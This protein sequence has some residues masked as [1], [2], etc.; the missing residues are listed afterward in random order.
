[1]RAGLA[2]CGPARATREV[3]EARADS[4]HAGRFTARPGARPLAGTSA[5]VRSGSRAKDPCS[6]RGRSARR[7]DIAGARWQTSAR[8]PRVRAMSARS[9]RPLGDLRALTSR[10]PD[11]FALPGARTTSAC[12]RRRPPDDGRVVVLMR[13]DAFAPLADPAGGIGRPCRIRRAPSRQPRRC[14]SRSSIDGLRWPV[15]A[16]VH[17]ARRNR[18]RSSRPPAARP[19]AEKPKYSS[20]IAISACSHRSLPPIGM[21]PNRLGVNSP[22]TTSTA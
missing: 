8:F 22:S 11:A 14:R 20:G 13:E 3:R 5:G 10:A 15:A 17:A 12:W 19:R 4:P 21:I 16:A 6:L 9:P 7:C 1:M 2:S 18:S